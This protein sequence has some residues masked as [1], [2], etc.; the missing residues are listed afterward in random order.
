MLS[1]GNIR[2]CLA[3]TLILLF[4]VAGP[5]GG[6]PRNAQPAQPDAADVAAAYL[7]LEAWVD[8]LSLPDPDDP[9]SRRGL[10]HA[11]GVCVILRHNGRV[12]GTGADMQGDDLMLRRAAG[13]ALSAT[14]A[15]RTIANLPEDLRDRVGRQLTIELEVAGPLQPLPGRTWTQ[16]AGQLEPGLD[17]VLLRRGEARGTFFPA[18][19]LAANTAGRLGRLLPAL[20][21]DLGLPAL[22][23][24]EL[25]RRHGLSIYSFRTVHLVQRAPGRAPFLTYRGEV[26]VPE[27]E[28]TAERIASFAESLTTHLI[29]PLWPGDEPFGLM[30]DYEPVADRYV[31]LTASP[32]D[33]ALT[34]FA[35]GRYAA[36]P[37]LHWR[38]ALRARDTAVVLLRDLAA[39]AEGESDP[40]ADPAACAAI[41]YAVSALPEA[42]VGEALSALHRRAAAKVIAT[43]EAADEPAA[44][45]ESAAPQAAISAHGRA[46][47][48]GAMARL[49]VQS[50]DLVEAA[51]VRRAIDAAWRA[52][53]K[54]QQITL[55][56]WIGFAE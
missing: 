22:E 21:V 50:P 17:G 20:A 43:I 26:L 52:V 12:L 6:V 16:I 25:R 14:L 48:A 28:V 11:A 35:L 30:G 56:P 46:M 15:D 29:T 24:A 40:L 38:E 39:V 32:R 31:P 2:R 49:M 34:A 53:P 37:Q 8:A 54:Q 33:Q 5:A 36:A 13:R 9:A 10:E 55:L 42:K 27:D 23:P 1:P 47:L 18:Q 51:S 45:D 44:E 7:D 41:V 19:M 3:A 4:T